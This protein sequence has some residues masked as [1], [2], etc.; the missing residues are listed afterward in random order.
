MTQAQLEIQLLA[1]A[2]AVACSLCGVFLVLRRMSL[3]SDA[4]SHTVL[5]GI[6]IAFF[7]TG[8]MT[9]PWLLV[10]ATTAGVFTVLLVESLQ[11]TGVV[12]EDA[13]IG[14]VFPALFSIAVLLISIYSKNVHLDMDAVLVGKIALT[15]LPSRRLEFGGYDFGPKSLALMIAII[16]VNIGF[17]ILFFK[18]LKVS[19]FDP[20]FSKAIGFN[21]YWIHLGLVL[22]VSTTA[23]ASF[24]A[25][26]SILVV[27]LMAAPAAT[28]YLL[29]DKLSIML[30]WSCIIGMLCAVLGYWLAHF[31]D[32]SI[33]GSMATVAGILF[34][35]TFFFAPDR[36][37]FSVWQRAKIRDRK[38][39][40][41]L[42]LVHLTHHEGT[43]RE[44]E[45]C[46]IESLHLHLRW[47]EY[48]TRSVAFEAVESF[49]AS[50]ENKVLRLTPKGRII[51]L[52]S[53]QI[54]T[55]LS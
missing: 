24:D 8:D 33:A 25:V 1:M 15:P 11:K 13:A 20:A 43:I 42:L 12:R 48:E 26:G 9:S 21:P 40:L 29:T 36:G 6:V 31:L 17:I 35:L 39:K 30:V 7:L 38:F 54:G 37:L 22:S 14:L 3:L 19:T 50:Q 41:A 27:A 2:T 28:A 47:N 45:E 44:L 49:C 52:E 51:A 18:E 32:A 16:I 53:L 23:V 10:G 5:I 34:G 46:N 4:I 55:N